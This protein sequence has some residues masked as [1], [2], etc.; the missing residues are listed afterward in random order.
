M[1]VQ[2]AQSA[3]TD[4]VPSV[5][6][7]EYPRLPFLFRSFWLSWSKPLAA[8]GNRYDPIQL[9]GGAPACVVQHR[10][11]SVA[12]SHR[13]L[14]GKLGQRQE[15]ARGPAPRTLS[16]GRLGHLSRLL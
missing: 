13:P 14:V 16:A 5:F 6:R 10:E 4:P 2:K 3:R 11:R 8:R 1:E 15:W 9:D 12:R 7:A